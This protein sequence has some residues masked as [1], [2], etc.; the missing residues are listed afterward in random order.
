MIRP[1]RLLAFALVSGVLSPAPT[2]AQPPERVIDILVFGDEACP[3]P[4][5]EDEIVVCARRP[6]SERYRTPLRFR[7]R[8]DR[9]M[10]VSWGSRVEE[11]ED[12]Q[13]S[14]RPNGCS[15]DGSFG[16]TGCLQAMIRQWQ[17]DRR[18]RARE[19]ERNR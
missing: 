14:T 1:L 3:A 11:L 19:N 10:E 9:P 16:Q 7:D 15:V 6:E 17:A 4:S 5:S 12:A 8:S 2:L 18:A 13:R